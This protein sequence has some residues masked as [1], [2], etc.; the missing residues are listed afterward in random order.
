MNS[1]LFKQMGLENFDFGYLIIGML[2]AVLILLVIVIIVLTKL[3]TLSKKYSNFLQGKNGKSLEKEL[4]NLFEDN[5]LLKTS[6]DQN[7]KDIRK[8]Y[9]MMEYTFSKAG[10]NKYDAFS[11]MGGRLSYS[12]AL[13]NDQNDGFI[14]NSVHSTEGCYSYAK[15]IKNG[16]CNVEL[17][18]EEKK[19]LS[20]AL[21]QKE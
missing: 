21:N 15:V 9:K 12:L 17:G 6:V 3:S 1:D 10:L 20:M 13:L 7:K 11:E 5:R 16:V 19:A 8:L 4:V 14:L 18:D 2:S